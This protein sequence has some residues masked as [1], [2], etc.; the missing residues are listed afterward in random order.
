MNEFTRR[1]K[2]SLSAD[3]VKAPQKKSRAAAVMVVILPAIIFAFVMVC[4]RIHYAGQIEKR[5]QEAAHLDNEIEQVR[6]NIQNIQNRKDTLSSLPHIRR[7]IAK[8][9]LPLVP[10][11]P[12]QLSYLNE[13]KDTSD[14]QTRNTK[15]SGNRLARVK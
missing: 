1:M 6:Y 12:S 9:N 15:S 2:P 4:F 5:N 13:G 3:R 10:R 14:H 11:Q 7:Q 8:F